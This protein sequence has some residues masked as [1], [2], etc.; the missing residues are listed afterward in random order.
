MMLV[1]DQA[2]PSLKTYL[3]DSRALD[4]SPEYAATY[5]RYAIFFQSDME[6]NILIFEKWSLTTYMFFIGTYI[7]SP[8][9]I[10]LKK[11]KD[12]FKVKL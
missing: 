3:L 7:K 10:G 4:H 9:L 11:I 2:Q 6:T 5:N 8:L 12:L 1:M